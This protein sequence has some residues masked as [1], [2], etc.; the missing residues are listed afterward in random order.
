LYGILGCCVAPREDC[1]TQVCYAFKTLLHASDKNLAAPY[2]PVVPI[3]CTI[4][5]YSD[6]RLL[7]STILGKD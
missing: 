7:P 3:T 2:G 5:T 4:K 1:L 6:D